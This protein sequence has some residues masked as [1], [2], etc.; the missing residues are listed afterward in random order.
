VA[1]H[2]RLDVRQYERVEQ[3]G[4][5][6]GSFVVRTSRV[7]TE[8]L[9]ALEKP[10]QHD[11]SEC[12]LEYRARKLVVATGYY[13]LPNFLNVPGELAGREAS[14]TSRT[15]RQPVSC[16]RAV[17]FGGLGSAHG[18]SVADRVSPGAT[19]PR[20]TRQRL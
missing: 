10:V 15:L 19:R 9:G 5:S 18:G 16:S 3:V 13:D 20:P 7:S 12:S 2:Y 8:I 14:V 4:G 17:T 6:D 1:E 11:P